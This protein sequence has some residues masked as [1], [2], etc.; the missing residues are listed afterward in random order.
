MGFF[1]AGLHGITD[2]EF[3][4]FG[5]VYD[6]FGVGYDRCSTFYGLIL[7]FWVI[8]VA[9]WWGFQELVMV[10]F[11]EFIDIIGIA[12]DANG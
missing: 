6:D 5:I 12:H 7:A 11:H 3:G 2:F 1:Y 8:A 4:V 9:L 10:L